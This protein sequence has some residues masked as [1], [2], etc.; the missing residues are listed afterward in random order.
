MDEA[1]VME[2]LR[3]VEWLDLAY[4]EGEPVCAW[5]GALRREGHAE[6]CELAALLEQ[7]GRWRKISA[8]EIPEDLMQTASSTHREVCVTETEFEDMWGRDKPDT[9][10]ARDEGRLYML[11][12]YGTEHDQWLVWKGKR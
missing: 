11:R 5:C 9:T 4:A 2:V 6:D 10:L 12:K 8:R 7:P 3:F 1:K